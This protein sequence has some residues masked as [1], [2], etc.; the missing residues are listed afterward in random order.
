M[1]SERLALYVNEFANLRNLRLA[2][3]LDQMELARRPMIGRRLRY[4]DLLRS[5][6][7]WMAART[8]AA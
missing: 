8:M 5:I 7:W 3:T 2:D 6:R 1:P 4:Q